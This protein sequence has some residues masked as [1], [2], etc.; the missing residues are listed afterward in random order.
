MF[1]DSTQDLG[2]IYLAQDDVLSTNSGDGIRGTPPV[3]V[4]HGKC[5][6]KNVAI[7]HRDVQCKRR[8]IHPHIAVG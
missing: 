6:Q 8:C 5:V 3:R 4:E 7:A 2:A 1:L